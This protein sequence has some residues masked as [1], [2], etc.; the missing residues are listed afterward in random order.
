[1][2]IEKEYLEK[3]FILNYYGRPITSDKNLVNYYIQSSA[4]D[5]CSLAFYEFIR[6]H[7]VDACFF[8]HDSLTFQCNKS[9]IK[10][11]LNLKE[12]KEYH[13]NISIPVE[14][15]IVHE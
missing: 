7:N 15:N 1:M 3:G 9:Q 4:V 14:F 11:I 10:E 13:S 8:V 5:F 12:I 2:K 6:E